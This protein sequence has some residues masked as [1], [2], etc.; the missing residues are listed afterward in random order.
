MPGDKKKARASATNPVVAL[1]IP[2]HRVVRGDG[3]TGRYRWGYR[4]QTPS[5]HAGENRFLDQYHSVLIYSDSE[6][7]EGG[8]SSHH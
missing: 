4:A 7:S 8:K 5:P 2:G 6:I 3:D 1:I